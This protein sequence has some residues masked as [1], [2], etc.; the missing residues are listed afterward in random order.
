MFAGMYYALGHSTPPGMPILAFLTTG[1]VP[2]SLFRE[3]ATR[4]LSAIE[5]NK[6]LLFYPLVRPLDLVIARAILE[7]VTQI[8]VMAV[9][10]GSMALWNGQLRINSWLETAVG[11]LLAAG[12][13]S[14]FG[15][16]C[17]GLSVYSRSVERLFPAFVRPIFWL[18]AVFHP[19]E[20]LPRLSRRPAV[21]PHRPCDRA[22]EKRLVSWLPRCPRGPSVRVHLDPGHV[23]LRAG[24][25]AHGAAQAGAHMIELSNVTKAYP[26][27]SGSNVVLDS[28]S[29][30]FPFRENIGILGRNG[31]GKSTLLR[32]I[33]GTEQ[34]DSG[35]V[36]RSGTVS[37]PIGFAGGFN[38]SLSG[39]ENC[40]FVA[41]IYGADVDEVVGFTMDFAELGEY[42]YM[43]VKTYSSGMKARLAFGLSMAIEF[44]AYLVDEVTAVGDAQF[45]QKCRAAFDAR[46]NRSAVIIV[47][48]QLGTIRDY[49]ERCA[50][51]KDGQ[52]LCFDSV[53]EA[54]R[55]YE[56]A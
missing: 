9:L 35:R 22:G 30:T 34:P 24:A 28:V 6:G 23:F 51:L 48:H 4:C 8:V 37:W 21:Q 18:S 39:E 16:V 5:A 50:V 53:D 42:F 10:L 3:A 49:C 15:L 44:D 31:S 33:A 17:C 7:S 27:R 1:I 52:L 43:P 46:R 11:L 55:I 13:G 54:N 12:L 41:R 26:T 25:R 40:R 2:F 29:F 20:S 14:S 19:V 32:V 38:G 36:L 45:Q 47:S 56:A